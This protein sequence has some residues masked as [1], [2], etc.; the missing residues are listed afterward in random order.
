MQK[1]YVEIKKKFKK[2]P[3]VSDISIDLFS[4]KIMMRGEFFDF[5]VKFISLHLEVGE[6]FENETLP[7][8][9]SSIEVKD[10]TAVSDHVQFGQLIK[11]AFEF[12]TTDNILDSKFNLSKSATC[13]ISKGSAAV[14]CKCIT[15][16]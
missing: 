13:I 1:N 15:I 3:K 14:F 11:C 10:I 8:I 16:E 9:S 2:L 4:I 5:G 6:F 12:K 7:R